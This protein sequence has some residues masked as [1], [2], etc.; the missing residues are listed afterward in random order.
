M[1]PGV[2]QN[3]NPALWTTPVTIQGLQ[4]ESTAKSTASP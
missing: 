3:G 4:R 2:G 1:M